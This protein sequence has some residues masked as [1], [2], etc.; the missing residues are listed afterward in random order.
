MDSKYDGTGVASPAY[1]RFS[2][3]IARERCDQQCRRVNAAAGCAI[4]KFGQTSVALRLRNAR[5]NLS[6][7]VR[8]FF[9]VALAVVPLLH[10][11]N[12]PVS[13]EPGLGGP[14]R[15]TLR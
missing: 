1:S 8:N 2:H 13:S 9:P 12:M 5:R 10:L 14:A 7:P 15:R 11:V 3:A 6:L 4:S